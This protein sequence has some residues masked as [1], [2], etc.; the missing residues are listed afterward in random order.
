MQQKE[1]EK[2]KKEI[3]EESEESDEEDYS[4]EKNF[5]SDQE[6][7]SQE[8]SKEKEKEGTK[9]YI[10]KEDY[11][12]LNKKYLELERRISILEKEKEEMSSLMRTL[13]L[14]NKTNMHIPLSANKEENINDLMN[15]AN[16]ELENKNKIINELEGK[17]S[18]LNLNNVNEF[19][20]D[21]L[22]EY[23]DFYSK[24]LKTINDALKKY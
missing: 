13:F 20:A 17:V 5:L 1:K 6:E 24:Q 21:K 4:S 23:K 11:D 15:L 7:E 16:K 22:K 9:K 19:S 10:S 18:K 8:K 3:N 14:Q 12:K 2:E